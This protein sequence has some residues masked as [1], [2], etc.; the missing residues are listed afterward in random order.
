MFKIYKF[1]YYLLFVVIAAT[2]FRYGIWSKFVEKPQRQ[3][4][5]KIGVLAPLTGGSARHGEWIRN[6]VSLAVEEFNAAGG[7][8]SIKLSGGVNGSGEIGIGNDRKV[9]I[10]YEDTICQPK[11]GVSAANKLINFDEVV[12]ILGPWCSSVSLAVAPIVETAGVPMISGSANDKMKEAGDYIFRLNPGATKEVEDVIGFVRGELGV[13]KLAILYSN[14]DYGFAFTKNTEKIFKNLGGEVVFVDAYEQ[15]EVD[16]RAHLLRVKKAA[17]DA[18]YMIG[19]QDEYSQLLRQAKEAKIDKQFISTLTFESHD[20][21]DA[22]G[23][24]TEGVIYSYLYD[25]ESDRPIVQAYR[26]IYLEK[27]GIESDMWAALFYDATRILLQAIATSTN[28]SIKE[29]DRTKI[30]NELYKIKDFNG[31]TNRL[32]FDEYGEVVNSYMVKQVQSG[33]FVRLK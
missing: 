33:K 17:P 14:N 25:R 7:F 5:I 9:E 26:K 8:N 18:I 11:E 22:A 19:Y 28:P 29:I 12:A 1:V 4:T 31:V 27:Y 32:G 2:C 15:G 13:S 10:I 3:E 24:A 30:K 20:I 23:E 16:Y 21:L 6:G